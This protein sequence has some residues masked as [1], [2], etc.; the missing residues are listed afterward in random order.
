MGLD[1]SQVIGCAVA[2]RPPGRASP[3][4]SVFGALPASLRG[5]DVME[6]QRRIDKSKMREG[7]REIA[8]EP[9]RA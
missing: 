8:D 9:F 1:P 3:F 6:V 4:G 5:A 2:A 7:L